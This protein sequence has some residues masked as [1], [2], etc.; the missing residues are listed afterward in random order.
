MSMR[1]QPDLGIGGDPSREFK[2]TKVEKLYRNC[3]TEELFLLWRDQELPMG[4][5]NAKS[6]DSD[7]EQ[8][9]TTFWFT[10]P[11]SFR[12]GRDAYLEI[13]LQKVPKEQMTEG[14]MRMSRVT[15]DYDSNKNFLEEKVREVY[16]N[17]RV[18]LRDLAIRVDQVLQKTAEH[19]LREI[20]QANEDLD[21]INNMYSREL[22]EMIFDI[23]VYEFGNHP[24]NFPKGQFMLK[25]FGSKTNTEP[26]F[27]E[28]FYFGIGIDRD[29][30]LI[31]KVLY[32]RVDEL[33]KYLTSLCDFC[34]WVLTI[35]VVDKHKENYRI[36]SVHGGE[37][38]TPADQQTVKAKEEQIA[39]RGSEYIMEMVRKGNVVPSRYGKILIIQDTPKGGIPRL[40]LSS[41]W[42]SF[43][44]CLHLVSG[45]AFLFQLSSREKIDAEGVKRILG[46]RFQGKVA[47]DFWLYSGEEP[48]ML[49]KE[50]IIGAL[51]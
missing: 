39:R 20:S 49:T 50:D 4:Q 7:A 9:L 36:L 22:S 26:G 21:F 6:T 31:D 16:V 41:E 2:E 30:E 37:S 40:G 34:T 14:D 42:S 43:G 17:Q 12:L 18:S 27:T 48:L 5:P 44:G 51:Q 33:R 32:V 1:R 8:K 47:Y 15:E 13:D 11:T 25:Q 35:P 46:G 45:K 19:I 38:L 28:L 23:L 3:T 10:E 29:P 24:N